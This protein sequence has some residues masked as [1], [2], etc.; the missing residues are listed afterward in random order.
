MEHKKIELKPCPFCGREA[1]M[2]KMNVKKLDLLDGLFSTVVDL[3][4]TCAQRL[5]IHRKEPLMIGID[6]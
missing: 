1:S 5:K 2:I 3:C 6:G 4:R